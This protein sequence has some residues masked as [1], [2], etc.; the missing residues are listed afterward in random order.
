MQMI[1][2]AEERMKAVVDFFEEELKNIRT[3]RANPGMVDNLKVEVYGTQMRVLDIATVS[4]PEPMQL[5]IAPFDAQNAALIGKAI[6]KANI[7]IMPIVEGNIVRLN[8]PPMDKEMR[9]K[10]TRQVGE[11]A[12]Q[13]KVKIRQARKEANDGIKAD[14]ENSED[15]RKHK[16]K[17][18]QELTDKFCK[19]A[20]DQAHKKEN[21]ISTI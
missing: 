1:K 17:E 2:E 18:V 9:E 6:E 7:G 20:D 4:V 11:M 19:I 3:G 14:K 8:I 16:E 5:L 12:E 13:T 15:D 21:E 10:M